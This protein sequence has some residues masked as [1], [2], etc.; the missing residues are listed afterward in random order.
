MTCLEAERLVMS[1]I[2]GELSDCQLEEFI[3]H[4]KTCEAC[5]EELEI[6]YILHIAMRQL[7]SE[8]QKSYDIQKML[9]ENIARKEQYLNRVKLNCRLRKIINWA[10]ALSVAFALAAQV[11]IWA[12]G[13]IQN[14]DIFG[15]YK[16]A[17]FTTGTGEVNG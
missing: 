6:Y 3:Y 5:Y 15:L 7:D 2:N 9:K 4:I 17:E 14:I 1:Y 12:F 10:A 11:G 16:E 8:P 13:G